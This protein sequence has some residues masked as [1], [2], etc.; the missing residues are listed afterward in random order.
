[1]T[2]KYLTTYIIKQSSKFWLI[3]AIHAGEKR[4]YNYPNIFYYTNIILYLKI[5]HYNTIPDTF[6]FEANTPIG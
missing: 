3:R 4:T 5:I 6:P 1:M 2:D